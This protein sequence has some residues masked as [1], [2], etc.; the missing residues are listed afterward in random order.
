METQT[1]MLART[2]FDPQKL[3]PPPGS[4]LEKV[5]A[6][7]SVHLDYDA[8]GRR[9][10]TYFPTGHREIYDDPEEQV[11]AEF[12]AKLIEHYHYSANRIG[13][14][15]AVPD[16]TPKDSADLVIFKDDARK[17]LLSSS[18]ASARKSRLPS[19]RN[20]LSRRSAMDTRT[21]FARLTSVSWPARPNVF[22]IAPTNIPFS[23]EKPTSFPT[24]RWLTA[25]CPNTSSCARES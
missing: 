15:I 11:R 24:C 21:S 12:W 6:K 20:L 7:Q 22:S 2:E 1:S 3:L 25:T 14:E 23:N 19:S 13:I 5:K 16:R 18:S 4:F 9:V 10:I 8:K 17:D